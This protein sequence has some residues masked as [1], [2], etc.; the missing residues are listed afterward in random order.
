M[1]AG[2]QATPSNALRIACEFARVFL[3][4]P[5]VERLPERD[6]CVRA[7]TYRH[8][9]RE[10]SIQLAC[11]VAMFLGGLQLPAPVQDAQK[12]ITNALMAAVQAAKKAS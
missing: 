12:K 1:V 7:S 3:S 10:P 4:R 11:R 8:L 2:V 9:L 5:E 6:E